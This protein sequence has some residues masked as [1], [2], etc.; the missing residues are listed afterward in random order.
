MDNIH[1]FVEE[2]LRAEHEQ[3]VK[4][5]DAIYEQADPLTMGRLRDLQQTCPEL[6]L[7]HCLIIELQNK[8]DAATSE[9]ATYKNTYPAP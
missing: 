9:L 4:L 5:K 1:P 2:I 8:L 6:S 7:A 3:F